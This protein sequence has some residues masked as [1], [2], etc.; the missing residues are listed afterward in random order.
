[1]EKGERGIKEKREENKRQQEVYHGTQAVEGRIEG[2]R[3]KAKVQQKTNRLLEKNGLLRRDWKPSMLGTFG[4]QQ[5]RL[6][7]AVQYCNAAYAS[8]HQ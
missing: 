8:L 3:N 6:R 2:W 1:M 5:K 7:P 4:R